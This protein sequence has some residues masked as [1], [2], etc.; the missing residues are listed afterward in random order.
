MLDPLFSGMSWLLAQY[1]A[2]VPSYAVAIALL[3]LSV[4][5]VLFPLILKSTRS[6]L[7][8]QM[9]QP[10]LNRLKAELGSDRQKFAEAQMALLRENNVNPMASCLPILIQLPVM[11]VMYWMITGLSHTVRG[12]SATGVALK[13]SG[14]CAEL[15]KRCSAPKYLD[16]A[17]DL[18]QDIARAGGKLTSFSVDLAKSVLAPH[19]GFFDALPYYVLVA[20]VV[21][22]SYLQVRRQMAHSPLAA[23]VNPM[24][25]TMNKITPIMT[26]MITLNLPAGVGLY[27]LVSNIFRILQ[28]EGMYRW[29]PH[30]VGHASELKVRHETTKDSPP[31][32]AP[33]GGFFS[34]LMTPPPPKPA[35]SGPAKP[36][37]GRP[38]NP[39]GA[40]RAQPRGSQGNRRRNNKKK[41]R[42]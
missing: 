32:P 13:K 23:N 22:T 28:L 21:A 29:D 11:S 3:T 24:I 31:P 34:R 18:Y 7:A 8:M 1:Y 37:D 19:A 42:R 25:G 30:V 41:R 12:A 38:G 6:I 15:A 36:A 5:V 35:T 40:G 17:T 33:G 4:M 16:S 2:L 14:L 10:E 9:L 27:F 20:S 39:N 26:G